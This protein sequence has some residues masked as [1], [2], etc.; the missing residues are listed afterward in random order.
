MFQE[1][2]V[3]HFNKDAANKLQIYQSEAGRK[4]KPD[5]T[6]SEQPLPISTDFD[7]T[8]N[9]VNKSSETE[10]EENSDEGCDVLEEILNLNTDTTDSMQNQEIVSQNNDIDSSK[11]VVC[12]S[13]TDEPILDKQSVDS[14]ISDPKPRVMTSYVNV[15]KEEEELDFLL[16][17]ETP[18][19]QSVNDTASLDSGEALFMC[20]EIQTDILA[21]NHYRSVT[22][23]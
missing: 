18:M 17:L 14:K 3:N 20:N 13:R 2:L 16:S 22:L 12:D 21:R 10:K 6:V 7:Q 4:P 8:T 19:K 5:S 15:Q 23:I 1:D 11:H 9:T